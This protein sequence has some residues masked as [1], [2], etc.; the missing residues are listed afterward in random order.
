MAGRQ[1]FFPPISRDPNNDGL[2]SLNLA[3]PAISRFRLLSSAFVY[4]R[5][6]S[7]SSN[8]MTLEMTLVPIVLRAPLVENVRSNFRNRAFES[9]L[10]RAGFGVAGQWIADGFALTLAAVDCSCI[11]QTGQFAQ[12]DG[13]DRAQGGLPRAH[14]CG[15]KAGWTAARQQR[16][17][18]FESGQRP[19]VRGPLDRRR[20]P[21]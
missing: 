2:F 11:G 17:T 3:A 4:W 1:G 7:D 14:A 19:D 8:A 16:K 6:F 13:R 5:L 10:G 15:Q 20:V 18:H 9:P 21:E 12:R